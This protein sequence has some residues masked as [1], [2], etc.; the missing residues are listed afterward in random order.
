MK[1]SFQEKEWMNEL[2]SFD[3][4]QIHERKSTI[5]SQVSVDLFIRWKL[6]AP[7][8]RTV[9]IANM[10]EDNK[11]ERKKKNDPPQCATN[12]FRVQT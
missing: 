11:N 4:V 1:I 2:W 12:T 6:I 8:F 10:P 3:V 5:C 7:L 9:S